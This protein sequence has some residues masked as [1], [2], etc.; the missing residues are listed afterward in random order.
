MKEKNMYTRKT[1]EEF[2]ADAYLIH[3]DRYDYS[4]LDYKSNKTKI[5][6]IC[7]E[8]GVFLQRPSAHLSGQGC[9]K[10]RLDNRRMGLNTFLQRY[11]F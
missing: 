7:K 3:K 11:I 5:K 9:M 1:N 4:L 6:I 10:C 2:I 8:H